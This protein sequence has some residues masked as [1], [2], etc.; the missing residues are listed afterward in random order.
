MR[1]QKLKIKNLLE[2]KSKK[3]YRKYNFFYNYLINNKV[4][5]RLKDLKINGQDIKEK[6]PK[7][8]EKYYKVILTEL[9]S[10]VFDGA[11]KNER[12]VLLE[13]VSKVKV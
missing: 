5:I 7:I 8:K 9:L 4:P 13:E 11:L 1:L 6:Y 3:I 12:D 10:R 2:K